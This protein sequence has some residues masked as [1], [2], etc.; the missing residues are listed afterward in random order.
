MQR[1]IRLLALAPL[2]GLAATPTWAQPAAPQDHVLRQFGAGSAANAVGVLEQRLDVEV[3]G[4]Q[5]IA[6]GDDGQIYLLDQVN[7]RVVSFDAKSPDGPTRSLSLPSGVDPSDMVVSG[8]NIYVWDGKPI[9][10]DAKGQGATRSL[11]PSGGEVDEATAAMFGQMGAPAG[12][13]DSAAAGP[14]TRTVGRNPGAGAPPPGADAGQ[15]ARA[16]GL[17]KLVSRG[18]GPAEAAITFDKSQRAATVVVTPKGNPPLPKLLL[19]VR[20]HVGTVEVLDIDVD[21]RTYVLTENIPSGG[22]ATAFVVRF[23]K[24][25]ALEGVYEMP[26]TPDVALSRRFVSVSPEGEVYFLRTR[27]DVVDVVGVGF[28]AMNKDQVVDLTIEAPPTFAAA[29]GE[30]AI[31]PL[32]AIKLLT[33]PQIM[34]IAASF[35]DVTWHVT[36]A[37]YGTDPN[38]GCTGFSSRGRRPMFLVGKENQNVRGI[39]YCW[40]CHGQLIDIATRINRGELA[41]NVC[42]RNDPRP[43]VAGVDCS[44]FVSATWGLATHFSTQA[45][46]A[47]SNVISNP[48]DMR[49]GDAFN[50]PGSH[51]MLFAGFTPDRK[52]AVYE[53]ST[54]GCGGKVCRNI[55]P[56]S[57][58]LERGYVPR[59]YRAVVETAQAPA[60]AVA[61]PSPHKPGKVGAKRKDKQA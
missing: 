46:P 6:S 17:Q 25:G 48:W 7:G 41:G 43:G 40:G 23:G 5:A 12:D 27:K 34:Q 60:P 19:K 20:D 11:S 37:A 58:L 31:Q 42:T 29:P 30:V 3:E 32:A 8:G 61:R 35:A 56:L 28:R 16:Q 50:K 21:G 49:P 10:L 55:Y 38:E 9:R 53:S 14:L 24:T 44:A 36:P 54:G 33:R 22:R 1:S 39:P 51:V 59:R 52:A 13:A 2:C 15:Q 18:K 57:S 26:L 4:P 47:I 45:I